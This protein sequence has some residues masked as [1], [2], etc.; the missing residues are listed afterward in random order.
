MKE[1]AHYKNYPMDYWRWPNF[2]PIELRSKSDN[3]LAID[4]DAMD[5][6]QALR[7]LID[8]PMKLTSAYRSPAHNKKVGGAK[9][10]MHLQAKAFDVQMMGHDP[11]QF[12]SAA[13]EV[14]FTGFGFYKKSGFIHIDT[15]RAREWNERWFKKAMFYEGSVPRPDVEPVDEKSDIPKHIPVTTK[16]KAITAL[17]VAG[18]A[19]IALKFREIIEAIGGQF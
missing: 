2:K 17:I 9:N 13:R 12:E 3:K 10:S 6:L 11:A 15:G 5:K 18:F 14:G 8:K 1:Y 16:G 19:A 4:E 7:A